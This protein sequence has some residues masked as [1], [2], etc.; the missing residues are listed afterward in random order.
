MIKLIFASDLNG[1]I[2]DGNKLPWNLP[3]DLERF[4]ELTTGH[5]VLM[6][7]K[8]YESLPFYPKGLPNRKNVVVSR[9][10]VGTP[11]IQVVRDL[12]DY[13]KNFPKEE[14][15][16]IIGG[17]EIYNNSLPYVDEIYQTLIDIQVKG[18]TKFTIEDSLDFS[19]DLVERKVSSTSLEYWN[20]NYFRE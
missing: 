7:R 20:I 2:G 16:W 3:E 19:L 8:T 15:L 1:V 5:T 11:E 12:E 9:S 4:K 13:L 18:D 17:A 6:G 14:T 10:L